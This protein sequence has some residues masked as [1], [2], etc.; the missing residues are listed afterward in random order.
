MADD[1]PVAGSLPAAHGVPALTPMLG[2]GWDEVRRRAPGDVGLRIA[3]L[4][5]QHIVEQ[6]GG[7]VALMLKFDAK[8]RW[9]HTRILPA[10]IECGRDTTRGSD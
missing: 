4:V 5:I 7:E 9:Y 10:P 1:R 8:G 3:M 6:R 2:D